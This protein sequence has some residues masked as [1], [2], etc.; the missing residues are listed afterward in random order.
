M[1]FIFENILTSNNLL[2]IPEI[3]FNWVKV[4]EDNGSTQMNQSKEIL[5][6]FNSRSK[7][8]NKI[9][10]SEKI[11]QNY[12]IKNFIE[13]FP[14]IKKCLKFSPPTSQM[15]CRLTP[16]KKMTTASPTGCVQSVRILSAKLGWHAIIT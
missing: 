5:S 13:F 6:N 9:L 7:I 11:N 8:Y 2:I 1:Y 12:Q 14:P 16:I 15:S 4:S 3:I 10:N